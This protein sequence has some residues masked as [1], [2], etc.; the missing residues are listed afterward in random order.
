MIHAPQMRRRH[1]QLVAEMGARATLQGA[2]IAVGAQTLQV[3]AAPLETDGD[4]LHGLLLSE[5]RATLDE[6]A[7]LRGSRIVGAAF[8]LSAGLHALRNRLQRRGR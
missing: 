2:Q 5:V 7:R 6:A 3:V 1:A 4:P 8:R